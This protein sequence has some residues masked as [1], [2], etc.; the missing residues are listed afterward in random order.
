MHFWPETYNSSSIPAQVFDIPNYCKGD[1]PKSA[2]C[3]WKVL[4]LKIFWVIFDNDVSFKLL[5]FGLARKWY[6]KS[7]ESIRILPGYFPNDLIEWYLI[8]FWVPVFV[9]LVYVVQR[10]LF[11]V[12][13]I[14][15]LIYAIYRLSVSII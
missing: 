14:C 10:K 11:I 13:V 15:L 4:N 3:S 9:R 12:W 1:C 6:I 7:S 8:W 2:Y 5:Y